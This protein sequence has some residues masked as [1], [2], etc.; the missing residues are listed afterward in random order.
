M[1]KVKSGDG[2]D[3]ILGKGMG[4]I[5]YLVMDKETG[6]KYAMKEERI[7]D[8]ID[9]SENNTK[10]S[11]CREIEF[12]LNFA[13]NYPNNFTTLISHE[14][15]NH[16]NPDIDLRT[17]DSYISHF[18]YLP[19]HVKQKLKHRDQGTRCIQKIYSLVDNNLKSV[20][21]NLSKQQIYSMI[22]QILYAVYLMKN[23][24]Y[25]HN[26][27]HSGN[28]GVVETKMDTIEIVVPNKFNEDEKI[29][30]NTYG[31]LFKV[32]DY[33]NVLNDK[34]EMDDIEKDTHK[35]NKNDEISRFYQK[36]VSFP[37]GSPIKKLFKLNNIDDKI[38]ERIRQSNNFQKMSEVSDNETDMIY[39]YQIAHPEE[40][41]KLYFEDK[42]TET[43]KPI[44][45]C[46]IVDYL[47]LYKWKHNLPVA[48][49]YFVK[50]TNAM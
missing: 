41:Q 27:L 34:Y 37:K 32:I 9:C 48:I 42:Y 28:I 4:G 16:C 7:P 33:G 15:I 36:L 13:N 21:A 49:R 24:G 44:I 38:M 18:E 1:I 35:S 3:T 50:Q 10:H 5:V 17:E 39:L 22:T 30:L 8:D 6:Q 19:E 11:Q 23:N 43:F 47:V 46:D 26:D 40:F 2:K 25:T 29:N 20:I 45:L 12:S 31:K 14:I